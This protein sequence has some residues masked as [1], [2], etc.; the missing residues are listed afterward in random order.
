M[1]GVEAHLAIGFVVVVVRVFAVVWRHEAVG[2]HL[3]KK[4]QNKR[5]TI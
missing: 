1:V 2:A 4:K 3:Q 5:A